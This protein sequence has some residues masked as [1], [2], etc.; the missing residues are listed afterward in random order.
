LKD[1][2]QWWEIV[3]SAYLMVRLQSPVF[4]ESTCFTTL[5][6]PAN[7]KKEEQ[8]RQREQDQFARH[9]WWDQGKGWKNLLNNLRLIIQPAVF[10]CLL[11]PWMVVFALPSLQQGFQSLIA[12]M[13]NFQGFVPV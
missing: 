13:N 4:Q 2:E 3:W 8:R 9:Q 11:S 1:I 10:Y 5:P 6:S 7:A 12:M